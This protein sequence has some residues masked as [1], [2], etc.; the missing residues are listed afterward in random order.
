MTHNTGQRTVLT[1]I[2]NGSSWLGGIERW[3]AAREHE[4]KA[5]QWRALGIKERGFPL[6]DAHAQQI[7]AAPDDHDGR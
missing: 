3:G 6:V 5:K 1:V 2:G 4:S 7:R